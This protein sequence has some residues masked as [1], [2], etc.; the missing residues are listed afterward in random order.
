MTLDFQHLIAYGYAPGN[1]MGRCYSCDTVHIDLDKRAMR[2]RPCAE[3]LY[4]EAAAAPKP[5]TFTLRACPFCGH[6]PN[7]DNLADSVHPTNR[8]GTLWTAGCVDNEGGCNASVL[9]GSRADAIDRWNA[10]TASIDT[11]KPKWPA[12]QATSRFLGLDQLKDAWKEWGDTK[13]PMRI[14]I[15][16]PTC[17]N[18]RCPKAENELFKCTGSNE[19]G[20]V[21]EL[22]A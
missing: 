22:D 7:E 21:G 4:A 13:T 11:A 18:K 10:R 17:G 19:V 15:L 6:Q 5:P 3:K 8:E 12:A 9:G 2:C 20:Q 16:C 1:Y 14:M